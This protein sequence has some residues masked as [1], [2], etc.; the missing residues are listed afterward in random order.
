MRFRI[1]QKRREFLPMPKFFP[2]EKNRDIAK[3]TVPALAYDGK[4]E[5]SAWQERARAKLSELLGLPFE[6]CDDLM[7]IEWK[8]EFETF[9]E[10]RI[11]FQS[12]TNYWVPV[13]L[14]FP[15]NAEGPLPAVITLQDIP[16]ECTFRRVGRFTPAT[17]R[18]FP[19]VTA[20]SACAR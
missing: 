5:F 11:R 16:P 20:I 3:N 10:I 13:V 14:W 19:V 1:A 18:R 9:T 8:K 7:S 6:R 15:K 4:E 2:L 12:E 17:K